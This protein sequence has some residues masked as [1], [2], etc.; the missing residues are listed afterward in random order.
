MRILAGTPAEQGAA[1]REAGL[2]LLSAGA[3]GRAATLLERALA[4]LPGVAATRTD[5]AIAYL[6][7]GN[8]AAAARHLEHAV[9][10]SSSEATQL[11]ALLAV[12]REG[13]HAADEFPRVN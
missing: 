8:L 4:A 11:V 9:A 5:A 2:A 12:V 3:A 10:A 7:S 1:C 13:L 6:E